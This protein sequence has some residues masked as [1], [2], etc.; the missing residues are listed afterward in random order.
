MVKRGSSV[1]FHCSAKSDFAPYRERTNEGLQISWLKDG[2]LLNTE[3]SSHYHLLRNG[4]LRIRKVKQSELQN[5]TGVYHCLVQ[6]EY[7]GVIASRKAYLQVACKY[8][9]N[10]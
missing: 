5:D 10:Y 2:V 6:S 9:L 7:I 3:A 1:L 8:I 4:S